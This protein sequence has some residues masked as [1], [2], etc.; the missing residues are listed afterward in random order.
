M[1]IRSCAKA[2]ILR[3]GR[4]LLIRCRREDGSLSY[5][6][7]GGGQRPR[8]T[9]EQTVAREVL[10]ETGYRVHGLSFAALAEE[11]HEDP[12]RWAAY[13][14][15]AQRVLHIFWAELEQDQPVAPSEEDLGQEGIAWVPVEA[16]AKLPNLHPSGLQGIFSDML[17]DRTP[18]Y[19]GC[20]HICG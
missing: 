8:E 9:L 17:R 4:L 20:V 7:P 18:R 19:L 15:Y 12:A 1:A 13:P 14:D 6:L 5:D 2:L 3:Q 16:V 10:E 11:I